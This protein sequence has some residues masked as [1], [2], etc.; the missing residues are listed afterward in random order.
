MKINIRLFFILLLGL[1]ACKKDDGDLVSMSELGAVNGEYTVSKEAGSVAV[2]VLSNEKYKVSVVDNADWV[3]VNAAELQG[4]AKFDVSYDGNAGFPRRAMLDLFS[5]GSNRHDTIVIKQEGTLVPELAFPKTNTTVLGDGGEVLSAIETNLELKDIRVDVI[6]PN[7]G[8][9]DWVNNDFTFKSEN[10]QFAF[11]VKPNPDQVA[12]RNAQLRL[13]YTDGWGVDHITTLYLLQANAQNLFGSKAEFPEVRLWA[14]DKITSD[15]FIEGYVVSDAMNK[16][17]GDNVQ[18]TP[19]AIDYSRNDKTVYIESLDGR[20]GFRIETATAADNIFTRYSKVQLLLKGTTVGQNNNPHSY[21]I[22]GVTSGM[23]MNLEQG[24]ASA[25]PLKEK[26][27]SE[28]TDDDIYTYVTLK[29]CEFPVRK[30]SFTPV[31]EGYSPLFNANRISK[32]PLLMR[33]IMGNSMFLLTNMNVPYRRDGAMLPYGS[34]TVSGIVVHEKFT[35]FSYE[36]AAS[37]EEYG[38]IGRYQ[39]RHVGRSDI[40]LANDFSNSFSAL[41]TEYRYPILS[42][43]AALPTEGNN[44]RITLSAP[45]SVTATSDYTYLGP[46][47][48]SFLGNTNQYGN[49]VMIGSSKQNVATAT[50][51]DGKG[52]VSG[53]AL[54]GSCV[55]WNSER[56]RGEAWIIEVSTAS[57]S[58]NK[59]SLQ[60]TALNWASAGAGT[61][62]YW[63]VEWSEHGNMEGNWNTITS[64][65]VPDASNWSNTLMHQLPAFKNVNVPLPLDM[66]GK[67]RV[68]IRLIVDQNKASSGTTYASEPIE[69]SLGSALGYVAIRYNK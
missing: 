62:R 18:T 59:L 52:G 58:T 35:R 39:I 1:G 6:Y 54:N 11:S 41:L 25:L 51:S 55:W 12:L 49:G 38:N 61:P 7:G 63:K 14:G 5:P 13:S 43:G 8:E 42:S 23:V 32:Y 20:Y 68:Y 19:T 48:A 67:P 37:E 44:G 57:I 50:N 30:G 26:Y 40:K 4:D 45:V 28:L 22:T 29:D 10:Q 16:N 27:M 65:T 36:D 46:V 53:S 34:G 60:F 17:M 9:G 64:Y 3:K 15:I 33:D 31:N 24:T 47:G 21:N 56:N 2:E 66:L 69:R